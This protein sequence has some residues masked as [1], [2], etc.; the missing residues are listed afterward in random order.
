MHRL[1]GRTA[2]A[3]RTN[4]VNSFNDLDNDLAYILLLSSK[5]GGCGLNLIGASRLVMYDPD[6]NPAND[7]QASYNIILYPL[8]DL[9]VARRRLKFCAAGIGC[10]AALWGKL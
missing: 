5:A 2:P 1:D 7:A 8:F 4:I 10:G 3:D 6:W 9:L